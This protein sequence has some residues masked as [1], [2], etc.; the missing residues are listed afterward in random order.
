MRND[1]LVASLIDSSTDFGIAARVREIG[2][3]GYARAYDDWERSW[4]QRMKA[5]LA[6]SPV[7]GQYT[8]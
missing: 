5:A 4:K 1:T 2:D 3:R 7:S 8:R 6:V